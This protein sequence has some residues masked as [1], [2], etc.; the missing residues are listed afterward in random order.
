MP[1]FLI[2]LMGGLGS[3]PGTLIAGLMVGLSLSMGGLVAPR[4]VDIMPYVLM[5]LIV[6]FWPRG[7]MGQ[8]NIIE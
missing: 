7:L 8:Q 6:Y 2:V 1:S 5:C 4:F 3:I